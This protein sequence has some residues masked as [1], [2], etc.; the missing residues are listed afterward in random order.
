[1]L[2]GE[3]GA[4]VMLSA[5]KEDELEQAAPGCRPLASTRAGWLPT[6]RKSTIC[7]H[8][9]DE[10][11]HRMGDID[12]LVNNAGATW[13][14]PPRTTRSQA[15]DKVMHLDMRGYFFAQPG[16]LPSAA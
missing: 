2:S 10:T 3:A 1:M 11:L 8:L 13:V 12:V 6:A 5:R 16:R 14:R 4:R 9:V 7:R 15:W